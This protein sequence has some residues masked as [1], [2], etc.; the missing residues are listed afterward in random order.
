MEVEAVEVA[1]AVDAAPAEQQ[2]AQGGGDAALLEA[3]QKALESLAA[4]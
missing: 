3:R 2:D 1:V 4:K